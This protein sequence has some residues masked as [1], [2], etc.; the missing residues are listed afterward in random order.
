ML[1]LA[2]FVKNVGVDCTKSPQSL[3]LQPPPHPPPLPPSATDSCE[4][5]ALLKLNI[6]PTQDFW[7][8]WIEFLQQVMYLTRKYKV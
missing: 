2:Q 4:E 7:T 1:S 5:R 6:G 8:M 3:E